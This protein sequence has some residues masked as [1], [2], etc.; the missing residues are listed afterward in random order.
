M[1][2]AGF[3]PNLA[4]AKQALVQASCPFWRSPLEER[5]GAPGCLWFLD[6]RP[7]LVGMSP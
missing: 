4:S 5:G 3:G 2:K 6:L 7:N 1:G